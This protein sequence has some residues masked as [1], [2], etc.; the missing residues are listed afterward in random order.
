[1]CVCVCVCRCCVYNIYT[2]THTCV[3]VCVCVCGYV[4]VCVRACVFVRVCACVCM[5][6]KK[7]SIRVCVYITHA[8]AHTHTQVRT[9]HPTGASIRLKILRYENGPKSPVGR[10]G[11]AASPTDMDG[12]DK[13]RLLQGMQGIKVMVKEVEKLR[14]SEEDVQLYAFVHI[15]NCEART[16]SAKNDAANSNVVMCNQKKKF[17]FL[18]FAVSGLGNAF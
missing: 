17:L 16:R 11:G 7:G 6:T 8:R 18:Q 15:D 3:C 2:N 10:A 5:Y 13:E 12:Q 9:N 14:I 1:M 4:C